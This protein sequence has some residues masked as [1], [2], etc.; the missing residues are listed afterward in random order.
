V[1]TA[2]GSA[3]NLVS[4]WG[5]A[6]LYLRGGA[7][8][9]F[10]FALYDGGS[11]SYAPIAVSTTT[12][13]VGTTYHVVGTYDGAILRLYVNGVLEG[14]LARSGTVNDSSFGGAL[15]GG[16]WGTLPSPAFDGRLDEVAIYGGAL[17]TAR[18]Q[19]HFNAGL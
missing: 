15:A 14:T 1:P 12:V 19:A 2:S 18:V 8:P 11:S 17:T 6:L 5:T 10:V 13:A 3:W 4:K 16:G 9:R 7:S